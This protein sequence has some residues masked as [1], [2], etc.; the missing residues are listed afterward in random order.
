MSLGRDASRT[1][2]RHLVMTGELLDDDPE[3]AWAHADVARSMAG[4]IA[5]V[6]EAA[7]LAAYR[8]G[9]YAVALSELRTA[10]RLTG[11]SVHLPVLADCER[12]L[13][14][15]ERALALAT[16]P[17]ARELDRAGQVEMLIVAAGARTDLGQPEAAVVT[18]QV[19]QLNERV[20]EA[21]L[22]RLRVAY[23][24]ALAAVGRDEES[25]R[26]LHLA[27]EVDD[28]DASGA[29]ERLAELDGITF[30]DLD[31]LDVDEDVDE[32]PEEPDTDVA[33]DLGGVDKIGVG[34]E[35]DLVDGDDLEADAGTDD[36]DAGD[37]QEV[38]AG[39][40][41]AGSG[42]EPGA[43]TPAADVGGTEAGAPE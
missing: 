12:G 28:E 36:V 11:S 7:G 25:L 27:A 35:G 33:G 16:S 24:D 26:W 17:E 13:G 3:A 32:E 20:H 1:V 43:D 14:R 18:L 5:V 19:P 23:A 10:R 30:V 42:L 38:P 34:V 8:S 9:R 15:P 2:A 6:R 31:D 37:P 4:R 29:H 22:A 41:L 39:G 21:W 40:D